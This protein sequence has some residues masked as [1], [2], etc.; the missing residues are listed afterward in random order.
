MHEFINAQPIVAL[1]GGAA[2][3]LPQGDADRLQL[4]QMAVMMTG[5]NHDPWRLDSARGPRSLDL[6]LSHQCSARLQ[7]LSARTGRPARDI[8]A[9]LLCQA[10]A[11]QD[12]P[13]A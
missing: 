4:L 9:D 5:M 12:Q 11:A 8:A 1:G 3:V 10:I 2:A 13:L 7:A 6:E